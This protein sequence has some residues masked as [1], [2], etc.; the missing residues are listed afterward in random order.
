[1]Q[2][3]LNE[4]V[5]I[6]ESLDFIQENTDSKNQLKPNL[7]WLNK[8][9]FSD[10]EGNIYKIESL[11]E[12]YR[13]ILLGKY[14]KEQNLPI[15]LQ[16]NIMSKYSNTFVIV[17]K[18]IEL[19]PWT[20]TVDELADAW[21]EELGEKRYDKMQELFE[22]HSIMWTRLENSGINS[23]GKARIF[24]CISNTAVRYDLEGIPS[25]IDSE[26]KVMTTLNG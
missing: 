6:Q 5:K 14:F 12:A 1:M 11:S 16:E 17:T 8:T 3:I 10:G 26:G 23:S 4:L 24:D 25:L 18:Q 2:D 13:R 19:E 7:Y 21:K 20:G 9:V 22:K 15:F